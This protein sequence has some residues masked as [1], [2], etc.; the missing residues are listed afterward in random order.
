MAVK[1]RALPTQSCRGLHL[2]DG[3]QCFFVTLQSLSRPLWLSARKRTK[4][5][6]KTTASGRRWT[7]KA[8]RSGA[9]T[10]FWSASLHQNQMG[11]PSSKNTHTDM[12]AEVPRESVRASGLCAEER[13]RHKHTNVH[14]DRTGRQRRNV[15]RDEDK[16]LEFPEVPLQP[17][18]SGGPRGRRGGTCGVFFN[19]IDM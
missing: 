11:C 15:H 7:M 2:C 12:E 6:K 9:D 17:R 16:G 8:L 4:R 13:G 14:T 1:K 19:D 5:D 10:H 3:G 18:R